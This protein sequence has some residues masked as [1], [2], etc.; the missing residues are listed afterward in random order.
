MLIPLLRRAVEPDPDHIEVLHDG[1]RYRVAVKRHPMARRF[2]LRVSATGGDVVLT[3]P[4]RGRLGPARAF[5][6]SHGGWI[7]TRINRLPGRI[8]FESGASVPVRGVLH[9]IVHR[10]APRGLVTPGY[11]GHGEPILAVYGQR[12]HLERRVRDYLQREARRDLDGAVEK[13]T[14]QLGVPARRITIKDTKSRWGSCS[15]AGRLN[16]SWRLVMAPAFVLHYLAAHEVAHLREMN[17]SVRFWRIVAQLD[18]RWRE[19]ERW[20]AKHGTDLHR[21]G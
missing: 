2:T 14:V 18:P 1:A 5:A 12:A 8:A 21:Y 3:L 11:D 15:S 20:L 16:F 4:P 9:R 7:A 10:D 13:L 17:H 6:E 19:A